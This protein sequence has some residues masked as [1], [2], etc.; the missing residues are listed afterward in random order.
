MKTYRLPCGCVIVHESK[1]TERVLKQCDCCAK[2]W[3]DRHEASAAERA[4]ARAQVNG[5]A[6]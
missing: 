5:V 6:A 3:N 2:D 1:N 4:E